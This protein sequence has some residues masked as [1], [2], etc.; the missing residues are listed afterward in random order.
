[1]N[2]WQ[3]IVAPT[4]AS[5]G[6]VAINMLIVSV[7]GILIGIA[8]VKLPQ[9]FA[10]GLPLPI[11]RHAKAGRKEI[12][13]EE[14]KLRA[15]LRVKAGI[16]ISIWSLTLILSL[17]LRLA[18]TAGL[19][20][21]FLPAMVLLTFPVLISYIVIY[22]LFFFSRF[23]Q[24]SRLLDNR[25]SYEP[26]KKG[27]AQKRTAPQEGIHPLPAKALIGLFIMPLLYYVVM[28]AVSIPPGIPAQNH[29]HV[30]HQFGMSVMGMVGYLLGLAMS[31][32]DDFRP[33]LPWLR[34][35]WK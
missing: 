22:R 33:L 11:W 14:Y 34:T 3:Y 6:P 8:L 2:F 15:E 1:M 25:K 21:R 17:L 23:L 7:L 29:D 26:T 13:K 35:S 9:E 24:A 28:I 31:L 19:D 4:G 12:G 16:G 30:L 10:Q 32:G 18:G 5:F 20:T 27:K